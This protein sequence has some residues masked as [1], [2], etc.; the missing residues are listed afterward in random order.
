MKQTISNTVKGIKIN[1]LASEVVGSP[2]HKSNFSKTYYCR[3]YY[4]KLSYK[5]NDYKF[6][7]HDSVNAYENN[8]PLN[9]KDVM[10]SIL[11][12]MGC[13]ESSRDMQDFIYSFGYDNDLEL[14]EKGVKAFEGCKRTSIILH[15][16]FNNDEL[17]QLQNEYMDY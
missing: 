8:I 3:K 17:E 1:V 12:D 14:Y 16:L 9:K 15:E 2:F 5:G 6:T 10:Y 11:S 4:V 13:Y 7:F